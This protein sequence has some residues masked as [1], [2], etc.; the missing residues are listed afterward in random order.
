M[1]KLNVTNKNTLIYKQHVADPRAGLV[2]GTAI[3]VFNPSTQRQ[4][5]VDLCGLKA[6]LHYIESSRTAMVTW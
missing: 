1:L 2:I 3:P 4:R 6:G 5:Q